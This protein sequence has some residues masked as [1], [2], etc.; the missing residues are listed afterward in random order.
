MLKTNNDVDNRA[1][2]ANVQTPEL[3]LLGIGILGP[4]SQVAKLLDGVAKHE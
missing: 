2:I 1:T 4:R 3:D